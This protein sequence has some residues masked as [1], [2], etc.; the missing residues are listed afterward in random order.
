MRRNKIII[1]SIFI[2]ALILLMP[3]ITAIQQKTIEERI[4]SEFIKNNSGNFKNLNQQELK[5]I[6]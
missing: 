3:S 1:S 4:Y 2:A 6:I 5:R